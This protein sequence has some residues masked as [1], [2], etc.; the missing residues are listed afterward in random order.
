[1]NTITDQFN[2][3]LQDVRVS[4][5]DRCNFRCQYCMPA[6]PEKEYAFL[7]KR[8]WLTGEEILRLARRHSK[9][10]LEDG[11]NKVCAGITS[12]D[13]VMRVTRDDG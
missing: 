1:M 7:A 8:E 6:Q 2:R 11:W 4:V 13:E 12:V 10:M 9:A 5:I 3:P